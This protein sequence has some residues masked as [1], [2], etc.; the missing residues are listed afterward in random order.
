MFGSI[1]GGKNVIKAIEAVGSASG[2]TAKPVRIHACGQLGLGA[3]YK[4]KLTNLNHNGHNAGIPDSV[5]ITCA[6]DM[7]ILDSAYDAGIYLPYACRAGACTNCTGKV[8][9]GTVDQSDQ[10]ILDDDQIARGF[11]LLCVAYPRSDCTIE[12]HDEEKLY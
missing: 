12:T 4:V 10:I 1:I 7:Y 8:L 2:K 3:A 11:A 9:A 6:D 5:T